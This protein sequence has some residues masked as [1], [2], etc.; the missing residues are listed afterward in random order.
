MVF[1][2]SADLEGGSPGLLGFVVVADVAPGPPVFAGGFFAVQ[3]VPHPKINSPKIN[4]AQFA[5]VVKRVIVGPSESRSDARPS[6]NAIGQSS[7]AVSIQDFFRLFERSPL[8]P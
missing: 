3:E 6:F 5:E 4:T 2:T 8:V 7:K 1:S